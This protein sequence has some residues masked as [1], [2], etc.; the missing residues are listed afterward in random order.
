MR[1]EEWLPST[2]KH[3]LLYQFFVWFL[4]TFIHLPLLLNP[5]KSKLSKRQGDMAVEDYLEKGYLSEALINFV[6]LLGWHPHNKQEVFRLD[7]LEKEF[8]I[9]RIQK[10]SAVFDC[11]KLE[12]MNRQYL[13][14]MGLDTIAKLAKPYYNDHGLDI[15]DKQKYLLVIDYARRRVT[16]LSEMPKESQ[17]FY[18]RF[19]ISTDNLDLL[20]NNTSQLLLKYIHTSLTRKTGCDGDQFKAIVIKAGDSL[21]VTGKTLFFPIRIALYGESKGPDIPHI[22]SILKRDETLSRLSQVIR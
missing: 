6:A 17:M 3:V 7:E 2:P 4:P 1:G 18:D 19:D 13:M 22:F 5:D 10:S 20:N 11:G 15:S 8:S 16:T 14:N 21:G 12:W 9:Q